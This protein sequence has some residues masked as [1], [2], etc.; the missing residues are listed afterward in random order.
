M[1]KLLKTIEKLD[2]S[3]GT[4]KLLTNDIKANRVAMLFAM[5]GTEDLIMLIE[6]AQ[7]KRKPVGIKFC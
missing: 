7:A 6:M 3:K 1:A 2:P 5:K 4:L